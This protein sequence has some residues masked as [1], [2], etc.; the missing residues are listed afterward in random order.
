MSGQNVSPFTIGPGVFRNNTQY[1]T[2]PKWYDSNLIRWNNDVMVPIGGWSTIL[3]SGLIDHPIRD[4]FSWRDY[5][6]KPF[7]ATGTANQLLAYSVQSNDTFVEHDITPAGLTWHEESLAGYG[8]GGYGYGF[9]GS[10]DGL[11]DPDDTGMWSMDNYGRNL[12]AVHSQDGR[13]VQWDP[14]VPATPSAVVAGAPI[15]NTLVVVTDEE[16]VMLLG[17]KDKPRSVD[18]SSRRDVNDWTPTDQNSAGGFELQSQGTILA[19]LKVQGGILVWTD[20]DIHI[21]EY[22]GPPNYYGRRRISDQG[23]IIGKN[24]K[25]PVP[26]G[27]IWMGRSN[28]W[29]WDGNISKMPC[30]VH[31]EVFK[32]SNLSKPS[33]IHLSVNEY[34]QE[35]WAF[36]PEAGDDEPTRYAFF[37]YNTTPYWAVGRLTRTAFHNPVWTERPI[38]ANNQRVYAHESGWLDDGNTRVGSVYAETGAMEAG[39]GDRVSRIDRIWEDA[40]DIDSS[41]GT[42]NPAAIE[43]YVK[44]RQAPRQPERVKGPFAPNANKGF[45]TL[46]LRAR[47][48]VVR[49]DQTVD[50]Y[51]QLGKIRIRTKEGGGR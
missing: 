32:N 23:G 6:K 25:A 27:C 10:D 39:E 1:A 38:A 43:Y 49:I 42:P 31:N 5:L 29:R 9:Y 7:F 22:I 51:W 46:R 21:I 14:T 15:D 37:S 19:A 44:L 8:S 50:D 24:A 33:R 2:G 47:Q 3:N 45:I 36:Y 28:F 12:L 4:I 41:L 48:F 40:S 34:G 16:F 26:G 17:G 30:S 35:V 18:W 11:L 20:V 13:L